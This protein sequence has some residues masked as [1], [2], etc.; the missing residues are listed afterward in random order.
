MF[1]TL[2]LKMPLDVLPCLKTGIPTAVHDVLCTQLCE[3][4]P[5][6][7]FE[8]ALLFFDEPWLIRSQLPHP[9]GHRGVEFA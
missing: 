3:L 9:F 6:T 4:A 1:K 7:G 2:I 5:R 8:P